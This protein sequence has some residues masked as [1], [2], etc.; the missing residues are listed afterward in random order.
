MPKM[1]VKDKE[2]FVK[3]LREDFLKSK[4]VIVTDYKGLNV[5]RINDLRKRLRDTNTVF[6]VVKNTM[7]T[8]AAKNTDVDVIQESFTGPSAIAFSSEDPVAPAKV[9]YDFAKENKALEIKMGVLEGRKLDNEAIKALSQLPSREVL[10]SRVLS[11]M[12]AVPT[13]FVRVLNNTIGG[14]LNVLTAIKEQKESEAG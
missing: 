3:S 4:V 5:E 14:M 9:L 10:L 12:N 1:K 13:N 6:K 2:A 7:L 8:R 11:A